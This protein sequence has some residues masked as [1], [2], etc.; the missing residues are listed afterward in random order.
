MRFLLLVIILTCGFAEER[1]I[2]V[3]VTAYCPCKKCC[4]RHADGKTSTGKRVYDRRKHPIMPNC[5]GI[6][7]A[8]GVFKKG[9]RIIV[10]GYNPSRYYPEDYAWP[11]DDH[12]DAM[13]DSLAKGV[14]HIDL[15]FIHHDSAV[16]WGRKWVTVT[17]VTP[18]LLTKKEPDADEQARRILP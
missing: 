13:E 3:L 11:V 12:G 18:P 10:P 16:K 9:T 1:E 15:R 6:A 8:N 2:R 7:A 14:I 4:G 17:V 5:W